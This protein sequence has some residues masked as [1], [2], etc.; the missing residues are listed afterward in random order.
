VPA[1]LV[2]PDQQAQLTPCMTSIGDAFC[3]PYVFIGTGGS[4]IPPT[5][6]SVGGAEGQR[7]E[8]PMSHCVTGMAR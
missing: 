1:A 4:F 7:S 8:A 3:T 6:D 5:C 2:P